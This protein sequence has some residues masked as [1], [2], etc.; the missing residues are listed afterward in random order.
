VLP[1]VDGMDV[2]AT[3]PFDD[4]DGNEQ[5]LTVAVTESHRIVLQPTVYPVALTWRQALDLT[6]AVSSA[7]VAVLAA[8]TDDE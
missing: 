6:N 2:V 5:T 4:D 3:V 1:K 7:V 8:V